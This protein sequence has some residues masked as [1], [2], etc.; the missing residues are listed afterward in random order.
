MISVNPGGAAQSSRKQMLTRKRLRIDDPRMT[1]PGPEGPAAQR[2]RTPRPLADPDLPRRLAG[3][4]AHRTL[5]LRRPVL[6]RPC[7]AAARPDAEGGRHRHPSRA[8]CARP[9]RGPDRCR[10]QRWTI[11]AATRAAVRRLI[12][13]AGARLWFLPPCSPDHNPSGVARPIRSRRDRRLQA[14]EASRPS[15]RSSTGCANYLA[16]AG[17]ASIKT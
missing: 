8:L 15:P 9:L 11:S 10:W 2:L 7:R 3:R 13:A 6:S 14:T 5:R 12:T 16:N 1:V 17:H 4:R